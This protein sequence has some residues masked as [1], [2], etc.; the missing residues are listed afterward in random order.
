MRPN[1]HAFMR[2][3]GLSPWRLRLSCGP[4]AFSVVPQSCSWRLGL[5]TPQPHMAPQA[6]TWRFRPC[7]FRLPS[8]CRKAGVPRSFVST[9]ASLEGLHVS[10]DEYE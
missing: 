1:P 7:C 10:L 4:Q 5:V 8:I 2:G 9:R 3:L 6:F